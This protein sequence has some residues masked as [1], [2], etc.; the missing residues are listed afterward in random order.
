MK[1][2]LGLRAA[3]A[4]AAISMAMVVLGA[5]E[6]YRRAPTQAFMRQK[7]IYSQSILEGL[8]LEKF[9]L[10][11]KNALRLRNMT[12]TNFWFVMKH[13]DYM[14]QTTNY[15]RN[16][17]AL[18]AAAMEKNLDAATDAYARLAKNC[19]EC[20][21]IVRLEQHRQSVLKSK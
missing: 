20:H 12:Q 9:D 14:L 18:Y 19:V 16:A 21:R 13:S 10:V 2:K 11:S 5:V 6:G 15:Q 1:M 8:A 7:L 3:M 17:E 4:A